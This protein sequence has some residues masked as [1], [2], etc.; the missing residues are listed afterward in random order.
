MSDEKKTNSGGMRQVRNQD[1]IQRMREGKPLWSFDSAASWFPE[2]PV[3]KKDAKEIARLYGEG[4]YGS[5]E[6][7]QPKPKAERPPSENSPKLSR[8]SEK[9]ENSDLENVVTLFPQATDRAS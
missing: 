3:I 8:D 9:Q 4:R 6:G 2:R 1:L 5:A 7:G